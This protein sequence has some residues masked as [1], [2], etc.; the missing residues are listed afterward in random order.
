MARKK[1]SSSAP[2]NDLY[3]RKFMQQIAHKETR[4]RIYA[5]NNEQQ[6]RNEKRM[7]K[8]NVPT[9]GKDGRMIRYLKRGGL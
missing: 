1:Q 9:Q 8:V 6:H 7:E 3:Q 2:G 5:H 4:G